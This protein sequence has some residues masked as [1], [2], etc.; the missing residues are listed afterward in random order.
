M[1]CRLWVSSASLWML[2][3]SFPCCDIISVLTSAILSLMSCSVALGYQ[4]SAVAVV[5]KPLTFWAKVK[6]EAI[7]SL[8]GTAGRESQQ[9]SD[10]YLYAGSCHRLQ[11]TPVTWRMDAEYNHSPT[12]SC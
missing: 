2:L 6:A 3:A 4:T 8:K 9:S 10:V 7:S 11:R 5:I 12:I 1:T